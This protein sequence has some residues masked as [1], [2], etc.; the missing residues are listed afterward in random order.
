MFAVH[1]AYL[2]VC[3]KGNTRVDRSSSDQ[4][5]VMCILRVLVRKVHHQVDL[6]ILDE[7][8]ATDREVIYI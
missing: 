7:P 3:K 1:Q 5:V 8:E 2:K 6:T 4:I